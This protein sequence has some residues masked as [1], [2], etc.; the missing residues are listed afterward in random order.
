MPKW[1]INA[2]KPALIAIHSSPLGFQVI[3]DTLCDVG[4]SM[5]S[6]QAPESTSQTAI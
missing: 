2:P 4:C 6:I 5:M 3:E 1:F